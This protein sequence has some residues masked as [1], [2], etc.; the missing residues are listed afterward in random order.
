[1]G[2]RRKWR[3]KKGKRNEGDGEVVAVS[4]GKEENL[5]KRVEKK[6]EKKK[7][8]V[9]GKCVN[10]SYLEFLLSRCNNDKDE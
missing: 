7:E 2:V 6:K 8:K 10:Q 3:K 9:M 1:M 4:R 5:E